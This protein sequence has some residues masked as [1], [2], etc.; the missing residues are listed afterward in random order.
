MD[1]KRNREI[2][3]F[4][5]QS[6]SE[7]PASVVLKII[8]EPKECLYFGLVYFGVVFDHLALLKY[9]DLSENRLVRSEIGLFVK[10]IN[11]SARRAHDR[12]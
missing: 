12:I 9:A 11:R 4:L 3:E 8:P 7:V 2:S 1:Q 5:S 10:L 6:S